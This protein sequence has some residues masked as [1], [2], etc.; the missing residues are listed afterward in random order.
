V[1]PKRQC[2]Q[3]RAL[4]TFSTFLGSFAVGSI[5]QILQSLLFPSLLFRLHGD[6]LFP[7]FLVSDDR[8][9]GCG[10]S[11]EVGVICVDVRSLYVYERG[12]V[13]RAW[14]ELFPQKVRNNLN[15]LPL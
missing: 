13:A 5:L 6:L 12:N 2:F 4:G 11:K 9:H 8:R 7:L 14:A 3:C 15:Q 1:F 10:C